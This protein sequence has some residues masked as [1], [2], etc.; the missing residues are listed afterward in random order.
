VE[1]W[2]DV[3]HESDRSVVRVAGR[4]GSAQVPDLSLA[5]SNVAGG[6]LL[7]D[8]SDLLN[9]DSIGVEALRR[10]RRDGATFVGVSEYLRL[11]LDAAG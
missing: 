10:L 7:I 5:C 3:T 8:L 4:L 9:A 1:C 2:I 11:K 6:H